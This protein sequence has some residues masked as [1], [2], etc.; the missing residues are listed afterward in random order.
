MKWKIALAVVAAVGIGFPAAAATITVTT[1]DP[2]VAQDGQC[3]LIEAVMNANADTAFH[4][5]CA[6]GSGADTIELASAADYVLD[7]VFMSYD[8][9]NGLPLVASEITVEGNGSTIERFADASQFRLIA[10]TPTGAL[11]LRDLTLRNGDAGSNFGGALHSRG[12]VELIRCTVTGN[13]ALA[14][15]G[16]S[17]ESGT[18]TVT[19]S[20]VS[21]NVAVGGGGG[22]KSGAVEAD[23]NLVIE[24][25][26]ITG[27]QAIGS[28]AG[29][30]Y[31]VGDATH[32]AELQLS[33]IHISEP[34][35]PVGIS[36]MPSSA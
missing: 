26:V 24:G 3:S 32:Q 23:A 19:N 28:G 7:Q 16:L 17:N 11:E 10:V 1:T 25:S 30:I 20:V 36:R 29:G 5:D 14:G 27:N 9:P 8:G 34:T 2:A 4:A 21:L 18:M 35:R 13:A 22:I 6:A 33:L 31:S 15:G 12:G